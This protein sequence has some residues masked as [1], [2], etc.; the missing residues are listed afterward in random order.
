MV[1]RRVV[2][3]GGSDAGI[4]AALRAKQVDPG[5]SVEVVVADAYPNYS[6]C[7]IPFFLSGEVQH[8]ASLAHR[9]AR[10]IE[11]AGV[12][13]RLETLATEID[14]TAGR[15]RVEG[16]GGTER[17]PY[18]TLV[19]GTGATPRRP[20]GDGFEHPAVY[21]L[22]GMGTAFRALEGLRANPQRVI[23]VGSG[24]IGLEM[25]D[26]LR[27]RGVDDVTL[28]GSSPAPLPTVDPEL[29]ALVREEL[30]RGG[31]RVIDGTRVRAIE[32]AGGGRARVLGGEGFAGEADL[33]VLS[34]GVVPETSLGTACGLKT[35]EGGALRVDRRMGTKLAGVLAAG[36]CVETWHRILERPVWLPLGTTAH[37]QGRVAGENAAGGA[38]AFA[39]TLGTQIVKVFELAIGRTGL[40][41]SEARL[42]GH[43]A[44]TIAFSGR[45]HKAYYPG[46][47]ETHVRVVGDRGTGRLLGAQ[48]VGHWRSGVAKRLDVFA[49]ALHLGLAVTEVLDLD[50]SYTPPLGSPWDV[51]QQAA[52]AWDL[53]WRRQTD[54]S[55]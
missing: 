1:S 10:E 17:L 21:P 15:L 37:K 7:G 4:S 55:G 33:V 18:D 25:A 47:T 46:A 39:G 19:L 43:D 11:R 13:L 51:V 9:T 34:T 12:H 8:S 2:I 28:V 41:E 22:H 49:A 3:V 45:D 23:V 40:D 16:P 48:L 27:V 30:E 5:A 20:D 29:G 44:A 42:A 24:Y 38:A 6:I 50:L 53:R 32:D 36:D 52:E 35:G 54:S 31:V 14:P 26:A